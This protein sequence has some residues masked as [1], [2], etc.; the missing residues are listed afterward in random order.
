MT[1]SSETNPAASA[2]TL[3]SEYEELRR[4]ALGGS[5][6]LRRGVGFALLSRRGMAAWIAACL[7]AVP[8]RPRS[9]PGQ[10]SSPV[11][12]E[13]RGEL[14]QLLASMALGGLEGRVPA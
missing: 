13:L 14:A 8:S 1:T 3:A 9:V 10:E 7:T 5:G 6:G 12:P 11:P 2:K 4:V